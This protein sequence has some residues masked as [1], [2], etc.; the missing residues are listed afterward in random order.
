MPNFNEDTRVKLPLLCHMTRLGYK[1]LSLKDVKYD[2]NYNI[3]W[4]IFKKSIERINKRNL[5]ERE[6]LDLKRKVIQYLHNEDLGESFYNELVFPSQELN[7]IDFNDIENNSYHVVTELTFNNKGDEFRPDVVILINGMPLAFYE[8]KKPNNEGGIQAEFYR[9]ENNRLNKPHFQHFFNMI[10]LIMFSNNMEYDD[11]SLEIQQG[12]FY[13]TPSGSKISPNFFREEDEEYINFD[14]E[15]NEK[16]VLEML[17]DLSQK[18]LL[19]KKEFITNIQTNRPAIRMATSL[20]SK[21]RLIFI[22]KYG[23][24]YVKEDNKIQK[25]ILRYPQLFAMK[26]IEKAIEEGVKSG[27]IW[28]TQGSGKTALSYFLTQYLKKVFVQEGKIPKFY[29]IVDRL[30]LLNQARREFTNRGLNVKT[31]NSKEEFIKNI[32]SNQ[33]LSDTKSNKGEINVVNIQKFSEEAIFKESDYNTNLQRVYFMDEVHRGYNPN[34]RFLKDLINSD[35]DGVFIG[36]T[37]T[38]LLDKKRKT[39]SIFGDYIHKYF[40]DKSIADKYTLR[41][42]CEPIKTVYK[43][44]LKE[45]INSMDGLVKKGVISK[46]D[47]YESTEYCEAM[48]TFIEKDFASFRKKHEDET[49][50]S[51]IVASSAPQARMLYKIM[52]K[53]KISVALVL[54]DEGSKNEIK[55]KQ[56]GFKKGKY[57]FVIVYNML[58]TGFNAPRLKRLYLTRMVKEHNLLQTLTRVNRPY[59]DYTYGYVVDFADVG[60]E[61]EKTNEKYQ[62]ELSRDY[63]QFGEG[64]NDVFVTDEEIREQFK[65]TIPIIQKFNTENKEILQDQMTKHN[66]NVKLYEF[67]KALQIYLSSKKELDDLDDSLDIS[68]SNVKILIRLVTQH[69][70]AVNA[71]RRVND[72]KEIEDLLRERKDIFEYAF[73]KGLPFELSVKKEIEGVIDETKREFKNNKNPKE[74]KY[75][76]LSKEFLEILTKMN[77]EN[78][79]SDLILKLQ[80]QLRKIQELNNENEEIMSLYDNI[81]S[82]MRIHKK[83][84]ENG[85]VLDTHDKRKAVIDTY[86]KIDKLVHNNSGILENE[87]YFEEEIKKYVKDSFSFVP[88]RYWKVAVEEYVESFY[89]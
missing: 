20:L 84:R 53:S 28:H 67:R 22:L 57:N 63:E 19:Y 38:P 25:H 21:E 23:I 34:G 18:Q 45:I 44:K 50:G 35:K 32:Q 5:S 58:L 1:Y 88:R 7:L 52:A 33:A 69:I 83:F 8:V 55:E 73:I 24:T 70:D 65:K 75:V 64:I 11:E 4:D 85:I 61:Y 54:H 37:G 12:S 29:F 74:E 42:K 56:E 15:L 39:T 68:Q 76:L 77:I 41:L 14:K 86:Q 31:V 89:H 71:R 3:F 6:F 16:V 40:Y 30:D 62:V 43:E 66:D 47:I 80:E 51:M 27:V 81:E 48:A 72:H 79:S 2:K 13:A 49:I 78:D 82:G 26:A 36:L 10:Q 59:K 87:S 46:K 60:E 17:E 9:M